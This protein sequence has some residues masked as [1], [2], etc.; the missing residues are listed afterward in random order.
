M[1]LLT[2]VWYAISG[3]TRSDDGLQAKV[4]QVY[5]H[6]FAR[7]RTGG[8]GVLVLLRV[9]VD[10]VEVHLHTHRARRA[11][12]ANSGIICVRRQRCVVAGSSLR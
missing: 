9:Q 10:V 2:S 3:T 11:V 4:V 12:D 5:L 6:L 1:R 7:R 8:S